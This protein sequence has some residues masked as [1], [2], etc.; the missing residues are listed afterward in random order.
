MLT[1]PGIA[2]LS[3]LVYIGEVLISTEAQYSN[4]DTFP[5]GE[6]GHDNKEVLMM[7]EDYDNICDYPDLDQHQDM[8]L[9]RKRDHWNRLRRSSGFN[10][11]PFAKWTSPGE[12]TWTVP[13]REIP[14]WTRLKK[15]ASW[16]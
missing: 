4:F 12:S 1:K 2:P 8:K 11:N 16:S 7:C 5:P 10:K 9:T 3:C 13:K 15:D 14:T 6:L